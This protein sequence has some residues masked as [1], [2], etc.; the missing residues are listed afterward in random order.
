MPVPREVTQAVLDRLSA[1]TLR[2]V[3]SQSYTVADRLEERA[4][5]HPDKVFVV[6]EDRVV[7]YGST[8]VYANR[9]AHAAHALGLRLG[10]I[11]PLVKPVFVAFLPLS[12]WTWDL[13]PSRVICKLT[14]DSRLVIAGHVVRSRHFFVL[15]ALIYVA[16][17]IRSWS[18]KNTEVLDLS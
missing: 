9:V 6:F 10:W 5:A 13:F 16:L 12:I 3:P 14:H 11:P 15:G 2:H 7:S 8:N 4:A 17:L 1:A 18:K